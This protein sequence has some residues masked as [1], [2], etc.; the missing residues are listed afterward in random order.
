MWSGM[1]NETYAGDLN[2]RTDR[3]A[4][5][6]Q[7]PDAGAIG[8]VKARAVE[9]LFD[10]RQL[11]FRDFEREER[12]MTDGGID[13]EHDPREFRRDY[14]PAVVREVHN[15]GTT[16]PISFVDVDVKD[17][18]VL[19]FREWS[20]DTGLLPAWRWSEVRFLET[21]IVKV[22]GE[23]H[24]YRCKQIARDDWDKLPDRITDAIAPR[25]ADEIEPEIPAG[26]SR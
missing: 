15:D 10:I 14:T 22:H 18:G 21:E 19:R 16:T 11:H 26:G 3:D 17:S 2:A 1:T 9:H 20:G 8:W 25:D 5:P 12:V 6:T 24:A 4:P 23:T 13:L 7:K